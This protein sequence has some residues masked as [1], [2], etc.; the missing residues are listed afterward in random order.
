MIEIDIT[1]TSDK[2]K[3][4]VRLVQ[5]IPS[6]I[7]AESLIS[8]DQ[9]TDGDD[10]DIHHHGYWYSGT[11]IRRRVGYATAA[12]EFRSKAGSPY[13]FQ[14]EARFLVPS[15]CGYRVRRTEAE[16]ARAW[17]TAVWA[18]LQQHAA[19]AA[20]VRPEDAPCAACGGVGYF[21][22]DTEYAG[23]HDTKITPCVAC[24]GDAIHASADREVV[25]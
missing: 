10:V 9:I 18:A 13:H 19:G 11:V 7:D 1:T 20:P 12:V 3:H 5:E 8:P 6:P 23:R 24:S 16:A 2:G 17:A 15:G 14:V 25:P 4:E 21:E 22:Y